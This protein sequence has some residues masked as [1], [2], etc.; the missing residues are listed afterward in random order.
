[1][2]QWPT[3][4]YLPR[5]AGRVTVIAITGVGPQGV[6]PWRGRFV[7]AIAV[8][9][10]SIVMRLIGFPGDELVQTR[11]GSLSFSGM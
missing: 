6:V 2:D 7:C 11:S 5:R 3:S 8:R 9:V 10:D 1:M 4:L